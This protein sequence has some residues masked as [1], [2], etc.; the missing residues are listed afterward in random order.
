MHMHIDLI[1]SALESNCCIS[2][3][4]IRYKPM[5]FSELPHSENIKREMSRQ[6]NLIIVAEKI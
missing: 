5:L 2:S 3:E 4:S 1:G 6:Y